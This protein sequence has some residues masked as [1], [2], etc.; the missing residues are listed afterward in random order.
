[1]AALT[2]ILYLS[3]IYIPFFG[4]LLSFLCPIPVMF[5]VIRWDLK[6]GLLAAGV[7]SLVV[8]AFAGILQALVCLLGFSFLGVIM[9]LAIKRGLEWLE[10]IAWGTMI[11]L[12]SKVALMG[13]AL[14]LIGENPVAQSIAIMEDVL[15]QN[16]KFLGDVGEEGVKMLI[17]VIRLSLPGIL[18]VASLFDTVLNFILGSWVGKKIDI[19]FPEIPPFSLWRLPRSVAWVFILGWILVIFGG[20]TFWGQVGLNVQIVTQTL[21][22]VQGASVI[23]F[24]L[25]KRIASQILKVI[26][27]LFLA[28]QPLFSTLI[29]WVGVFDT[30]F[31]FRKTK[32]T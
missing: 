9:G 11:S 30:W 24:F 1:M 32:G 12:L 4:F 23:Y 5:L 16:S 31:D 27:V 8:F 2:V 29:A 18:I 26:I 25:D 6:T 19:L 17:Q 13:L 10:V 15:N 22:L 20:V 14:L 3:S 7:A 28:I 21:F